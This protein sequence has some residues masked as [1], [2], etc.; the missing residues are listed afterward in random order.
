MDKLKYPPYTF[1]GTNPVWRV[2]E[3]YEDGRMLFS[4]AYPYNTAKK[5]FD[6][7]IEN[8]VNEYYGKITHVMIVAQLE[9]K[10]IK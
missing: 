10:E 7:A 4:N 2:L 5:L 3:R 1:Y 6:Q 9:A 8:P